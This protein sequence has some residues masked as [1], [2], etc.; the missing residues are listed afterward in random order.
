ML[1][2]R[3]FNFWRA[4]SSIRTRPESRGCSECKY[5]NDLPH[6][7]AVSLNYSSRTCFSIRERTIARA[8][9]HDASHAQTTRQRVSQHRLSVMPLRDN[10]SS[11]SLHLY[12]HDID[13]IN[14]YIQELTC[15]M[16]SVYTCDSYIILMQCHVKCIHKAG[17]G[18]VYMRLRYIP[19]SLHSDSV[20]KKNGWCIIC[21][22]YPH[23]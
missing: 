13:N 20:L 17:H 12:C 10:S 7:R 3:W 19:D 6:H 4:H 9:R 23:L 18:G 14:Q 21:S 22:L 5:A 1:T 11:G 15:G 16:A 2:A 8:H